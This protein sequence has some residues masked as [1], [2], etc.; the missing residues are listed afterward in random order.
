MAKKKNLPT[1][2]PQRR[3][4]KVLGVVALVAV[5]GLGG[6]LGARPFIEQLG[7][8]NGEIAA[9]QQQTK[10]LQT[11]LTQL[12]GAANSKDQVEQ[13]RKDFVAKFPETADVPNLINTISNSAVAAGIPASDVSNYAFQAPTLG[14]A[15]ASSA[16]AAA[17]AG[18][19]APAPAA[20]AGT[21]GTTGTTTGSAA[22]AGGS[23]LAGM[24]LNM[25]VKGSPRQFAVLLKNLTTMDRNFTV[26]TFAVAGSDAGSTLTLTATTYLYS[27]VPSYTEGAAAATSGTAGTAGTAGAA[28]G[29][30]QVPAT[31][32]TSP[33]T[34]G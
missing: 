25:T 19:T 18:T 10:S 2:N 34:G 21:T 16:G 24:T 27:H 20:S 1:T 33:A 14:G 8:S 15:G 12:Q 30:A 7:D 9:A 28:S 4:I 6:Y 29:T 13:F 23:K 3:N 5:A 17:A 31:G 11:Q 26:T 32:A 22:A